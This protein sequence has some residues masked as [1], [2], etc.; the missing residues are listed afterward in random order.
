MF[1]TFEIRSDCEP[2]YNPSAI[3][4]VT[5]YSISMYIVNLELFN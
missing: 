3:K 5:K 2:I 4:C 1:M